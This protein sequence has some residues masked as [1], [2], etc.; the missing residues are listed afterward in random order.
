[1]A[2]FP[3]SKLNQHASQ[4]NHLKRQQTRMTIRCNRLDRALQEANN[5]RR[6]LAESVENHESAL[7]IQRTMMKSIME[8][9]KELK[10]EAQVVRNSVMVLLAHVRCSK[11]ENEKWMSSKK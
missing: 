1:M 5:G 7:V 6:I 4:L 2:D 11:D 9:N 8:V 3:T 10:E